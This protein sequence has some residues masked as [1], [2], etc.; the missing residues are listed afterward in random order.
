MAGVV[1]PPEDRRAAVW[2]RPVPGS[3][4]APLFWLM[5]V[6]GGAGATTLARLLEPAA[7]CWRRWPAVLNQESPYVVLVARETIPGLS[8]AH[9]LLRQHR[10]GLAGPSSVLGLIITAARPGRVPAEIRRYREVIGVLAGNVWRIDWHEEWMLVEPEDLPVWV[11]GE[12]SPVKRRSDPLLT[13]SPDIR[14]LGDSILDVVREVVSSS[15]DY[16]ETKGQP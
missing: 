16:Q 12:S 10:S 7:D 13:V 15:T 2:D 9:E 8:R 1:P 3:G 5:G 6:H 14:E 11:P 4:R